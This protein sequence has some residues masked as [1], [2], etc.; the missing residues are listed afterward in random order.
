MMLL[1]ILRRAPGLF[2]ALASALAVPPAILISLSGAPVTQFLIVTMATPIWLFIGLWINTRIVRYLLAAGRRNARRDIIRGVY[3]D[4]DPRGR[5]P[6]W[7][8]TKVRGHNIVPIEVYV[9]AYTRT[10]MSSQ[11][12]PQGVRNP[13]APLLM[14]A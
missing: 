10:A 4:S 8:M 6:D 7:M 13:Q 2:F 5:I 9:E 1:E 14:V 3:L 12:C 11:V